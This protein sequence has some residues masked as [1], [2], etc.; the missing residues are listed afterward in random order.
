MLLDNPNEPVPVVDCFECGE[1]FEVHNLSQ[2]TVHNRCIK[3]QVKFRLKEAETL[4]RHM[5][6]EKNFMKELEMSE[7]RK[8]TDKQEQIESGKTI[9]GFV[10][11]HDSPDSGPWMFLGTNLHESIQ[12]LE[13]ELG[14]YIYEK[15]VPEDVPVMCIQAKWFTQDEI[16]SMP[17]FPG[18]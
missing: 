7:K 6:A 12:S 9:M 15:T 18:W 13:C 17:E 16:D 1:N 4:H 14:G 10:L 2:V 3:C 8:E 11:T 5:K